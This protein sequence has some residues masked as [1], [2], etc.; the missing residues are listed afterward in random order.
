M[1][2]MEWRWFS[3]GEF[4]EVVHR[5]LPLLPLIVIQ[6]AWI[7]YYLRPDVERLYLQGVLFLKIPWA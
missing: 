7:N 6:T 3:W 2:V 4:Y 1:S 5:A